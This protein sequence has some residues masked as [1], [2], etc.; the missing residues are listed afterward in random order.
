[1]Q[2]VAKP[3]AAVAPQAAFA[4]PA[5]MVPDA[6]NE[7]NVLRSAQLDEREQM[8]RQR[9]R[10]LA[11]QRRILAEEYRLLRA[12]HASDPAPGI[13]M[14]IPPATQPGRRFDTEATQGFWNRV[15]RVM[16]GISAPTVEGS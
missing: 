1:V 14:R 9:E 15:K 11:E 5:R 12:R 3:V 16:L 6:L 7:N 2:P 13:T 4:A 8:L 10:E